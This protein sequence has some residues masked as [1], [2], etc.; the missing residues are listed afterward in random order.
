MAQRVMS[1]AVEDAYL[2]AMPAV[3]TFEARLVSRDELPEWLKPNPGIITGYRVGYSK[4]GVV[5]SLFSL[6]NETLNMWTHM[7]TGMMWFYTGWS[8]HI[9]VAMTGSDSLCLWFVTLMGE[10][11][12]ICSTLAH[13][14]SCLSERASL[15]WWR[16]DYCGILALW[17]GRFIFDSYFLLAH[18]T[19]HLWRTAVL[20]AIAV[21]GMAAPSII[22]H[23]SMPQF[24][25]VFLFIHAPLFYL[26]VGSPEHTATDFLAR[27]LYLNSL[28]TLCAIV[29]FAFLNSKMPEVV[30]PGAFDIWFASHQWWHIFTG[31]GPVL[32]LMAGHAL[33]QHRMSTTCNP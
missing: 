22:F 4:F 16:V 8:I 12:F 11:M 5:K 3:E 17:F 18:C 25:G 10:A 14:C 31:A 13:M 2:L 26:I 28:A 29:G 27:Y 7:L 24:I 20:A 33:I 30:Y 32:S 15:L 1:T 9:E 23:K 6:H 21:F 19:P